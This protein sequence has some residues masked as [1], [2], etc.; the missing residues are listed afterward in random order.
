MEIDKKT[1]PDNFNYIFRSLN[2]LA[3]T[4]AE[5]MILARR[6]EKEMNLILFH[7]TFL[8]NTTCV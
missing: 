1:E 7:S 3:M 8:R 4:L 5:M 6:R 2:L